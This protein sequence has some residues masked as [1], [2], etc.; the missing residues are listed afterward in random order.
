MA[1]VKLDDAMPSHPKVLASGPLGFALDVAGICYSNAHDTDGFVPAVALPAVLPGLPSPRKHAA[2]LVAAG[3][4]HVVDGGWLIHD[5]DDYQ[6]SREEQEER[7]RKKREKAALG[8]HKRWHEG[9]GKPDPDC[10][11]CASSGDRLTIVQGSSGESLDVSPEIPRP[12][13]TRPDRESTTAPDGASLES[14][15]RFWQ[16]YPRRN[17]IRVGRKE[18]LAQWAKLTEADRDLAMVALRHYGSACDRGLTLAKDA[19]RWLRGRCW[20]EWE[21][22]VAGADPS[23]EWA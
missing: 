21:S 9:R 3:R 16:G 7:A 17:G 2:A 4:W 5:I 20:V 13:P 6:F 8:N 18:A 22:P 19:H 14:F 10:P 15:E 23:Q 11:L 12:D 1:W